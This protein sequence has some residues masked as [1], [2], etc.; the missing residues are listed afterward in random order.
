M[1][2]IGYRIL[3]KWMREADEKKSI[4]SINDDCRDAADTSKE[5]EAEEGKGRNIR[6]QKKR[7]ESC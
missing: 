3:L 2:E 7:F 1:K 6:L 5:P 4:A